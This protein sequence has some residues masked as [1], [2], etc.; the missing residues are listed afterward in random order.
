MKTIKLFLLALCVTGL[1]SCNNSDDNKPVNIPGVKGRPVEFN[2]N[3]FLDSYHYINENR[4]SKII[5]GSDE[6]Y[7]TEFHYTGNELTQCTF[8]YPSSHTGISNLEFKKTGSHKIIVTLNFPENISSFQ[9]VELNDSGLPIRIIRG[10]SE[11][12]EDC[13]CEFSYYPGSNKLYRKKLFSEQKETYTTHTFIYD[14]NPGSSSQ[15]D[16]PIW[17][18]I[19]LHELHKKSVSDEQWLN[20]TNNVIRIDITSISKPSTESQEYLYTYDEE[21]YPVSV[22]EPIYG[23]TINIKY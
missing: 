18:R 3:G 10:I 16:F 17:A 7:T 9:S 22:I 11:D 6:S 5:Y 20:Y 8:T 14:D 13:F 2:V 21:G 1:Y 4:L 12:E 19:Y 23:Y 15:I